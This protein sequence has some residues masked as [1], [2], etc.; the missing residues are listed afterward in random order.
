MRFA[1]GAAARE[2]VSRWLKPLLALAIAVHVLLLLLGTLPS[3]R[4]SQAAFPLFNGYL[5]LTNQPQA[6]VM[7]QNPDQVRAN[8]ELV[9]VYPDGREERPWGTAREMS[10]RECYFLE[11]LSYNPNARQLAWDFLG[12]LRERMP[13]A[14]RPSQLFV[15]RTSRTVVPFDQAAGRS[16]L[17]DDLP[18]SE[19]RRIW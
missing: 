2:R 12:V 8:Y 13:E 18:A 10:P 19:I 6:W 15:R 1:I 14:A 7:Y 11:A 4:F 17:G 16:P 9:A 3:S 5:T